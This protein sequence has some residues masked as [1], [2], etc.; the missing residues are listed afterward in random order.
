MLFFLRCSTL[1][2][3]PADIYVV[4]YAGWSTFPRPRQLSLRYITYRMINISSAPL[5]VSWYYPVLY[6]GWST[7]LRPHCS[8]GEY[9]LYYIQND[10]YFLDLI[11]RQLI[12]G[13]IICRMISISS[14]LPLVPHRKTGWESIA[15]SQV[16]CYIMNR[17][18]ISMMPLLT[19]TFKKTRHDQCNAG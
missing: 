2:S 15:H 17:E 3:S 5:L 19:P 12:L 18:I 1:S 16:G 6:T 9:M 7:F 13:C 4:L 8:S 10:Q 14:A 11:S